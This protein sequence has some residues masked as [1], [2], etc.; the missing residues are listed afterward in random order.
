MPTRKKP[1]DKKPKKSRKRRTRRKDKAIYKPF[2]IIVVFIALLSLALIGLYYVKQEMSHPSSPSITSEVGKAIVAEIDKALANGFFHIGLSSKDVVARRVSEHRRTS[3]G[4]TWKFED[5]EIDVP[6]DIAQDRVKT[7]LDKLSDDVSYYLSAYRGG[8]T[9]VF[10]QKLEQLEGM[11]VSSLL[12]SGM[13]THKIRFRFPLTEK[14]TEADKPQRVD[15]A[16]KAPL[17]KPKV[18]IIVDDVGLDKSPI[19]HL[20]E[21]QAPLS[22]AILPNHPYSSYAAEKA[23]SKGWDVMLHLPMEP[24]ES[25]GYTGQDAGENAL[26][27]GLPKKEILA[28]L[29][30]SLSS[31]PYLQGVNNHMGSKFTENDELMGIVLERIKELGLYFVD[32][33]TSSESVGYKTASKLGIRSLERDVFLDEQTKGASYVKSQIKKLVNISKVHGYAV[34]ICHPYPETVKALVEMIPSIQ[35]E[36]ELAS[37]S[38][39]LD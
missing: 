23:K 35:D 39:V 33:K 20:L 29:D 1:G 36:V 5:I 6:S 3:D 19:D 13:I 9:L 21:I 8:N 15:K 2:A 25:S 11:L 27:V 26:L 28:R 12:V 37:A 18:I 10:N 14:K 32:S 38:K 22:F 30:K 7:A 4:A 34:G 31:L 24:K 16:L 17:G